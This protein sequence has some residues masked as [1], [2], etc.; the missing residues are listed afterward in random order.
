[1]NL[2]RFE[3]VRESYNGGGIFDICITLRGKWARI[4]FGS[5][6]FYMRWSKR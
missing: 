6:Q 1:M 2:P 5:K 3:Y 4:G